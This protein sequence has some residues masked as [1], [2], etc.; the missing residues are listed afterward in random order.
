MDNLS[1]NWFSEGLVDFEYKKY[2]LL[3]YLQKVKSSFEAQKLYPKLADLVSHYQNIISFKENQQI[4]LN[5][6]PKEISTEAL[7]SLE[8]K[9]KELT[10]DDSYINEIGQI[11]E[12]AIPNIKNHLELGRDIYQEIED[13]LEIMPVGITPINRNFGYFFLSPAK[14]LFTY[15]YEYQIT[16]FQNASEPLRGLH[17]SFLD[18]YKKSLSNTYENIKVELVRNSKKYDNPATFVI[19]AQINAPIEESL[20][21]VAK[22]CLVKYISV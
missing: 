22:R 9:Y 1:L 12:F 5:Q 20:L 18:K 19:E 21:P 7:E 8:L 14:H 16:I 11:I 3:A 4:F 15:I 10:I 17:V 2:V 6:L 13:A